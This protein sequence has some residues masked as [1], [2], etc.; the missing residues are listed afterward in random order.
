MVEKEYI[1]NRI[2]EVVSKTAPEAEVFLYGSRARGNE[3]INSDWDL[4]ILLNSKL[5][6]FDFEKQFINAFYDIEIETGEI[7]SPLI[8]SKTDW[9]ENHKITPL[10]ENIQNDGVRLK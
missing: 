1:I 3:K 8:Y 7:I 6:T 5:L 9:F 4:L 10:F 2:I